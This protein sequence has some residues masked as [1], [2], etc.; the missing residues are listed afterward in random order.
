MIWCMWVY[1]YHKFRVCE[2]RTEPSQIYVHGYIYV[3]FLS[4]YGYLHICNDCE[5]WVCNCTY[6]YAAR[7]CTFSS[8][9]CSNR[10][11]LLTKASYPGFGVSH[12]VFGKHCECIAQKCTHLERLPPLASQLLL[13]S[14]CVPTQHGGQKNVTYSGQTLG[15]EP[16]SSRIQSKD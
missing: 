15:I 3:Q 16:G 9:K 12:T 14:H 1:M 4:M 13:L 5:S 6:T 8:Y 7:T 2:C 11:R 10:Q